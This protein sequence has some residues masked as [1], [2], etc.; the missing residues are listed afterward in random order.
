VVQDIP[1]VKACARRAR[2]RIEALAGGGLKTSGTFG[3][4]S[5]LGRCHVKGFFADSNEDKVGYDPGYA[6][7]T[8]PLVRRG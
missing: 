4:D 7:V 2:G 8:L 6:H 1:G 3:G 5:G